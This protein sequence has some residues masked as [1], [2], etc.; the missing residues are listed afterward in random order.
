MGCSSGSGVVVAGALGELVELSLP[1]GVT[2]GG[3]TFGGVALGR[4]RLRHPGSGGVNS[5]AGSSSSSAASE[6]VGSGSC[7]QAEL[8][9]PGHTTPSIAIAML[10][11][12]FSIRPHFSRSP[13]VKAIFGI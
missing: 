13:L 2:F 10:K 5:C 4:G 8:V 1:G 9:D 7:P 12:N 11:S 6:I 3:V